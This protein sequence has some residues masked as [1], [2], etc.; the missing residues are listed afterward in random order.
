VSVADLT[1]VDRRRLAAVARAHAWVLDIDGCL[2]RTARAGGVGGV[3]VPGAADLLAWLRRGARDVVVCTNASER[4]AAEYAGQL[5]GAGLEI[6]DEQMV[7][8]ATAAA[9][10]VARHHPDHRVLAIGGEGL[11]QALRKEGIEPVGPRS[12]RLPEVVVVGAAASYTAA[13]LNAGCLALADGDGSFYVTVDVPWFHGGLGRS[14]SVSSAVAA[15]ITAVTGRRPQVCGKPS[16]AL[17]EVLNRRL[18]GPARHVVVVGD[19]ASVEMQLA[20]T[21]KALGVLV[22]S[23]GTAEADLASL[24]A[25]HRPHLR[26]ADVGTLHELVSAAESKGDPA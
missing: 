17:A 13:D 19:T 16:P 25:E 12:D 9:D 3:P 7:T 1:T 21:M 18:G 24:P 22:M 6:A 4:P 14:L 5:R 15:A 8:A 10:Y 20:H 11:T 23:G 26:V 2:V